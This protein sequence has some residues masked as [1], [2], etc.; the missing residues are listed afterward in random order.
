MPPIRHADRS[1]RYDKSASSLAKQVTRGAEHEDP[2]CNLMTFTE[3]GTADRA[4]SLSADGWG[5]YAPHQDTDCAVMWRKE[6]WALVDSQ[7]K[8]LTDAT[9]VVSGHTHKLVACKVVLDAKD[10]SGRIW[11]SVAHFPSSVQGKGGFSDEHPDRVKAWKTGLQGLADWKK[12]QHDKWH[13]TWMGMCA[14]WNLD[15]KI[16]WCRQLIKDEFSAMHCTWQKPYPSG[17]THGDRLI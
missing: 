7:V 2:S 13:P 3:V 17:G 15:M 11:L 8:R 4:A 5:T 12:K 6:R 14:D 9:W 16:G 10:G 1:S